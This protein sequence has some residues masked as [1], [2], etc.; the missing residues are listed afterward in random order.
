MIFSEFIS[1]ERNDE[2]LDPHVRDVDDDR[3][4]DRKY[5]YVCLIGHL[6]YQ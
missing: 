2:K 3:G 6:S 4:I 1:F 5:G